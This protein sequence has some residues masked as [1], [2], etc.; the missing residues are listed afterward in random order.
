MLQNAFLLSYT[1]YGDYDAVL[2]CFTSENGF[3]SFFVRGI[4][5]PKNRKKAFLFPLNELFLYIS[6]K[7]KNIPN[8]LKIEQ[9]N[10]NLFDADIK[11]NSILFFVSD[12]LNQVLRN[13]QQNEK[14]Y[15]E[16]SCFL[17][18]LKSGNPQ[19]H[20]VLMFRILK[21]QGL[22]P[23]FS[24][25]KFLNPESGNFE[26]KETHHLFGKEISEIWKIFINSEN[27]Y[28]IKLNRIQR[29]RFLDS[30]LVYFHYHFTDFRE[31]KSLE[32]IKEIF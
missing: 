19:S 23:L 5:V 30:I 29:Q 12:L 1:K 22:Q 9:K 10:V 16:I 31:P 3:E 20:L 18:E 26:E 24:E 7:K 27:S 15:S 4:Y 14:I 21:Q 13:E 17:N 28:S 6:E 2:H 11:K 32:V 25:K 8:V